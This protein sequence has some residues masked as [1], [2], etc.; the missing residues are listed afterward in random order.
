MFKSIMLSALPHMLVAFGTPDM[1]SCFLDMCLT[2]D[3][4]MMFCI[5][6]DLF[7]FIH[8]LSPTALLSNNIPGLVSVMSST[9]VGGLWYT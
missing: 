6:S 1:T 9:H 3:Q 5:L 7:Y 8:P 2:C 4:D